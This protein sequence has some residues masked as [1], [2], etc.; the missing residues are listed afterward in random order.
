MSQLAL[1]L[2]AGWGGRREGAGRK[3]TGKRYVPH[4]ERDVHKKTTPVHVTYRVVGGLPTLR[5]ED[6]RAAIVDAI[7]G[8]HK[9]GYRVCHFAIQSNHIHLIVEADD[10]A[11]LS[12]GMQGLAVR[13]ARRINYVLDRTGKVFAER[14]HAH[15]LRSLRE[16][17]NALRYVLLNRQKHVRLERAAWIV[18][19]CTSGPW[20]DGWAWDPYWRPEGTPDSPVAPPKTW[21]LRVGWQQK[22]A[23]FIDPR[24][25]PPPTPQRP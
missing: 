11:T 12:R 15:E 24:D 21:S 9:D 6:L 1:K 19:D 18:D 23:P 3:R 13:M 25:T 20:F 8:A 17:Y 10:N 7:R 5:R 14:Y 22:V 16:V 2:P 4:L